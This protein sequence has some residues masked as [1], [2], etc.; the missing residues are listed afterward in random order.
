MAA[1]ARRRAAAAPQAGAPEP[2]A[3]ELL[4]AADLIRNAINP[5]ALAG[6]G[7]VRAGAAPALREFSRATGIAVA[8]TFMG[9]GVLDY[10]D[11]QR[12]R[13]RR[14]AVARLRD[15]RLRGRRRRHRHRLRPRR[16]RA[17]ALEPRRRQEDRRDRLGAG[18]DRRVLHARGRAASATSTTCSRGWPR[19][20]ATCRTRAAR[21]RLRD[22]VLGP[23]RAGQ[24]RRPLPDAAAARAVGD[25][26]GAGPRGHPHLRRRAAQAV[27]RRGCSP[28]TSPTPC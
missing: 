4:K 13:H 7:V 1:D 27:D 5:V 26:Q 6:N 25:P 2:G 18:R 28:R 19:S 12:A 9:K 15:G 10:E 17:E 24:G 3:R 23:L 20:A 11:P 14:A 21:S 8:E 16:A 22:V